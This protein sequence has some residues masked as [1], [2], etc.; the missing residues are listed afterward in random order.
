[1]AHTNLKGFSAAFK[2]RNFRYFWAATMFAYAG[3]WM[4]AIVLSWLVLKM[5]GSP[6]LT[7]VAVA[8]R[9]LGYGLGPAFGAW[10][11]RGNRRLLLLMITSTSVLYSFILALLVTSETIL[12]WHAIIISLAA[13]LAHGFDYPLRFAITADMVD[14]RD[15]SNAVALST[16]ALDVTAVLGPAMSGPLIDIIGISGVCWFLVGNYI[17]NIWAFYMIRGV[18]QTHQTISGSLWGNMVEG[19]RY[20]RGNPPVFA[21]LLMAAAFNQFHF[22]LR[23]ALMPV[24]ADKVLNVGASG[25]GFLLASSGIGALIGAAVMAALGNFRFKAWLCIISSAFAGISAAVFS[26]S[27][28]YAFSLGI[29]SFIGAMEAVGMTTIAALLLL[30]TPGKMQGRVMGM[31]SFAILP[32]ATGSMAAGAMAEILGVSV[33]GVIN[34]GLQLLTTMTVALGVESLRRS[35]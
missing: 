27:T 13:S 21:L 7:G 11:D 22:P 18:S 15:L 2:Y 34:G 4:E 6:F 17:L 5:T 8:C 16:V 10:G 9:W 32:L 33:A 24:F 35:G 20:I 1:M 29:M 31:R 28:V 14:T 19:A 26:V 23:N 3:R 12:Y 25:Y 30:L